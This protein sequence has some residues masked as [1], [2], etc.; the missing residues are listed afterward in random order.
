MGPDD[1]VVEIGP[2]L[3]ALTSL[4]ASRAG[5]LLGIE[6]DP[7]LAEDLRARFAGQ[8]HVEILCADVLK[9]GLEE[10]CTRYGVKQCC[11]VGNLPY[12]I[13]SPILHSLFQ[14]GLRI[15]SLAVLVQLEVARRLTAHPASRDYG[16]LTVMTRLFA[17]PRIVFQAPPGAFSPPPKV[18]SALVAFSMRDELPAALKT[19]SEDFLHFVQLCFAQKRKKLINNLVSGYD[20]IRAEQGM[21]RAGMAPNQRAEELS[22]DEFLLLY[23]SLQT[24]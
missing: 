14:S 12:Y 24:A 13:T 5:R 21:A 19:G 8:T 22:L 17:E 23:H 15:K 11:V 9:T 10:I 1:L 2:G 16:Y 20:R 3:G 7:G 6:I 4:L 18:N